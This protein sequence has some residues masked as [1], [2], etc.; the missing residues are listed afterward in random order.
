MSLWAQKFLC[1]GEITVI[2]R[3]LNFALTF[4]VF[5][6]RILRF[7]K[8]TYWNWKYLFRFYISIPTLYCWPFKNSKRTY[9]FPFLLCAGI[10]SFVVYLVPTFQVMKLWSSKILSTTFVSKLRAVV[11]S[12]PLRDIQLLRSHLVGEGASK[13]EPIRTRGR[14]KSCQCECLHINF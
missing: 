12:F 3:C 6:H 14:V 11:Q 10:V 1:L 9:F 13:C 5:Y 8:K 4:G 7:F 2:L